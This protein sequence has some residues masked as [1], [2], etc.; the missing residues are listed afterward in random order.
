VDTEKIL[1]TIIYIS[2]FAV[3]WGGMWFIFTKWGM[4]WQ[5]DN[6][7]SLLRENTD[8]LIRIAEVLEKHLEH[9]RPDPGVRRDDTTS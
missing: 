8:A 5:K 3:I 2:V 4:R 1:F 7:H 6:T 9:K